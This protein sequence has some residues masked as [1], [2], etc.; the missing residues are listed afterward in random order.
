MVN[1]SDAVTDVTTKEPTTSELV[2]S[3]ADLVSGMKS[4]QQQISSL[5]EQLKQSLTE[6]PDSGLNSSRGRP[7]SDR[8]RSHTV[9]LG[10]I[11]IATS[12]E[13]DPSYKPPTELG[14]VWRTLLFC[15]ALGMQAFFIGYAYT[16]D[17]LYRMQ[18]QALLSISG[19]AMFMFVFS[20]PRER[21]KKLE[22]KGGGEE[23]EV[24]EEE[25]EEEDDIGDTLNEWF[26]GWREQRALIAFYLWLALFQL[27]IAY[28]HIYS[29]PKRSYK[30]GFVWATMLF[31]FDPPVIYFFGKLRRRSVRAEVD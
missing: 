28:G 10:M 14:R 24:E 7:K 31:W 30:T 3:I 17:H 18:G 21:K 12:E 23:G 4:Q 2:K 1:A 5:K 26:F 15:L 11:E 9:A 20:A 13:E 22:E 16:G 8:G 19:G 6:R 27:S 25:E 29:N